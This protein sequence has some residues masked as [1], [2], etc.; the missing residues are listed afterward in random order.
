[1]QRVGVKCPGFLEKAD[2]GKRT[3]GHTRASKKWKIFVCLYIIYIQ[4]F[5]IRLGL[6]QANLGSF[7]SFA[8]L[9][10]KTEHLHLTG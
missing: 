4:F 7:S 6:F 5:L 2:R 3:L 8:L 9:C 10:T 1:M